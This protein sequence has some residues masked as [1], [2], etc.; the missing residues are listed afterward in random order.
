MFFDV[1]RNLLLAAERFAEHGNMVLLDI[2]EEGILQELVDLVS[3]GLGSVHF[4]HEPYRHFTG[5]EAGNLS[6]LA[7]GFQRFFQISFIVSLFHVDG[8]FA[9]HI[10]DLFKL[11]IHFWFS[12]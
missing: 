9:A 10:A 12:L 1:L 6:L 4:L 3:L 5:T 2:I 11:N 8:K 7:K